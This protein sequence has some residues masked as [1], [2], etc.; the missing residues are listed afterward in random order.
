MAISRGMISGLTYRDTDVFLVCFSLLSPASYINV[1]QDC[2]PLI[3]KLGFGW[4]PLILV[5]TKAD[6]RAQALLSD[7]A[8]ERWRDCIVFVLLL[9]RHAPTNRLCPL[10]PSRPSPLLS[11]PHV[12]QAQTWSR[13]L[14]FIEYPKTEGQPRRLVPIPQ[15]QGRALATELGAIGYMECSALEDVGV[16]EVF[17]R[18]AELVADVHRARGKRKERHCMIS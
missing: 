2:V 4:V 11:H 14:G 16:R 12:W 18:A 1:K 13:I 8:L 6:L 7:S 15:A 10:D 5:G 17:S 9:V 3:R